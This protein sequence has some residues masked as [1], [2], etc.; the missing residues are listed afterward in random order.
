MT[1]LQNKFYL[2]KGTKKREEGVKNHK[3]QSTW[4]MDCPFVE[5]EEAQVEK[6]Y[7]STNYLGHQFIILMS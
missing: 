6:W 7:C 1:I 3:N 5:K 4:F 2:V